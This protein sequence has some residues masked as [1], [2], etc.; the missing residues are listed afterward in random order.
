MNRS[1]RISYRMAGLVFLAAAVLLWVCGGLNGAA[2]RE[3]QLLYR[4]GGVA[5]ALLG[6]VSLLRPTRAR[7][8]LE[9]D[10]TLLCCSGY[11]LARRI[12]TGEIAGADVLGG[13][14][15]VLRL[16]SGKGVKLEFLFEGLDS[17]LAEL[18]SRGI[19]VEQRARR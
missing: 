9:D 16:R 8:R 13:R 10:G 15:M 4:A 2:E 11:G 1:L 6:L 19:P 14:W 5:V 7:L 18:R 3:A 17:F 12:P